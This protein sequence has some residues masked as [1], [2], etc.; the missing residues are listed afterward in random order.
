MHSFEHAARP[1]A[2]PSPSSADAI[3]LTRVISAGSS[4]G[5]VPPPRDQKLLGSYAKILKLDGAHDKRLFF[6]LADASRLK[7]P[8]VSRKL[9]ELLRQMRIQGQGHTSWVKALDLERWADTLE[10]RSR[11]PQLVRRLVRATGR[12][13]GLVEFPA[14]E[15]VQRTGWDGIVEA[16][17]ASEFVPAG[18]SGWEMG[19]NQDPRKKRRTIIA[20]APS[21]RAALSRRRRPSSSSRR[22]SGRTSISGVVRRRA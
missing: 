5:L 8:E 10:A 3:N 16:H 18:I 6:D 13:L 7:D 11:L 17:E 15:Q 1:S 21:R 22:G 20:I 9:P 2:S 14:H 12:K 19:V 4:G